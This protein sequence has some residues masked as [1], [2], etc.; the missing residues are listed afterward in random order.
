MMLAL[1]QGFEKNGSVRWLIFGGGHSIQ[2]SEF[3]K[4]G[5]VIFTAWLFSESAKRPDMPALP[6]ALA[7]LAIFVPC[8]VLEPDIGQTC[9]VVLVWGGLF[10]LA[11]YSLIWIARAS[12]RAARRVRRGL[13]HHQPCAKPR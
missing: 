8:L 12:R 3:A 6:L 7:T 4:P 13:F 1:L 9:L 5:F 11:G 2:P 10:F